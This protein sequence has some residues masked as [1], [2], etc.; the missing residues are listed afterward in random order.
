MPE[1]RYRKS[2]TNTVNLEIFMNSV[3]RHTCI[4]DVKS[5]QLWLDLPI[6]I[7]DRVISPFGNS[8]IFTKL[9]TS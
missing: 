6:S 4:Y 3:K 1:K 9:R 2:L 5:S 8:F 7:N